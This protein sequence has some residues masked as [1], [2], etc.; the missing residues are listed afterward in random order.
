MAR[1]AFHN[2]HGLR[3]YSCAGAT[4]ESHNS[5]LGPTLD[6]QYNSYVASP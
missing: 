1:E 2:G 3:D 6:D 4:L 5:M